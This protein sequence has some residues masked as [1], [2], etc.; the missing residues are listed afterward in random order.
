MIPRNPHPDCINC[1]NLSDT[2]FCQVKDKELAS[3]DIE[4]SSRTIKKGQIVFFENDQVKGLHCIRVGKVKLYRTLDD[5]GMQILRISKENDVIGYRGLLGNGQYIATAEALEDS[6]ICFIP[7]QTIFDLIG[8][9]LQFSLKLMSMFASDLSEAEEKSIRFVQKSS[10][11]RLAEA[12]L[13]LEASFGVNTEGFIKINLTRQEIAAFAG[14]ATETIIRNIK[15]W[16][17][18]GI[19]GLNKK[20]IKII[21]KPQLISISNTPE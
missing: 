14:L 7:K 18:S 20:Q 3:L 4:K 5:G 19:L 1:K 6:E 9:N 15:A 17:E 8:S 16:E 10:K 13:M 21:D 12:L 11:E 2:I